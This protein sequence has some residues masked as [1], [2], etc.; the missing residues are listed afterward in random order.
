MTTRLIDEVAAW[1]I[2]LSGLKPEAGL[3]YPTELSGGMLKRASM[4]RALA[5]DPELLFLDEPTAGLDPD[6]AGGID[7]L[8]RSLAE[9]YRSD[10]RHHHPRSGLFMAGYRSRRGAWRRQGGRRR[11]DA[12]TGPDGSP[13][14]P[15]VF[16]RPTRQGGAGAGRAQD[17]VRQHTKKHDKEQPWTQK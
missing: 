3:Q 7:A 11:L 12:G 10:H 8:V 6:G 17:Q 15:P 1:K 16:R 2:T 13:G 5:L 4:A 14:Y 9:L